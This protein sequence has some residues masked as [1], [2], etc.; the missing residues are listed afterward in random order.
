MVLR[1][2]YKEIEE[3]VFNKVIIMEGMFLNVRTIKT[4]NVNGKWRKWYL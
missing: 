2:I 1:I 3:I 4:V